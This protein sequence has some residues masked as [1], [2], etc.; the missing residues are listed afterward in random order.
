MTRSKPSD[1]S[2]ARLENARLR[3]EVAG[4]KRRIEELEQ[5]GGQPQPLEIHERTIR[6]IVD[7]VPHIL[8]VKDI[9]GRFLLVNRATATAFGL[10]VEQMTGRAIDEIFDNPDLVARY[11][12]D[13]LEVINTGVAKHIAEEPFIDA[14]GRERWHQAIKIPYRTMNGGKSAILCVSQDITEQK[15]AIESLRQSEQRL[16]HHISHTPL[17]AIVWDMG[18][19]VKE[20]NS[21]AENIF[22]Y[23]AEQAIGRNVMKLIV[24][25]KDRE[26]LND[27]LKHVLEHEEGVYN[28]S[29]NV[30]ES[31]R[32][33]SVEWYNTPLRDAEG[34]AIGVAALALDVTEHERVARSLAKSENKYRSLFET[35]LDGILFTDTEGVIQEANPA[36]LDML[37][38]EIAELRRRS[39]DDISHPD[40]L[41]KNRKIRDRILVGPHGAYEKEYLHK[42]GSWVP[43]SL[44]A[45]PVGEGDGRPERFMG[46]VRD[47][48]ES[49]AAESALEESQQLLRLLSD[50]LPVGIS[51]I[52]QTGRFRFVNKELASWYGWSP[53]DFIGMPVSDLIEEEFQDLWQPDFRRALA[54]EAVKFDL[55]RGWP[56]LGRRMVEITYVPD[57]AADGSVSGLFGLAQDVTEPRTA[58]EALRNSEARRR[59]CGR[60]QQG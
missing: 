15:K 59:R 31:G 22:G 11:R 32:T 3:Q 35:S 9:D 14:Q 49:K 25:E 45:W 26:N 57:I 30:T 1:D 55:E 2:S 38:Y 40:L 60:A 36:L 53:E 50:N 10:T 29:E 12:S 52:D 39:G 19:S 41:E 5:G 34:K 47:I 27:F 44:H 20:W 43:V 46:I 24:P 18:Y 33:V 8:F 58:E 51:Y 48:S 54:G 4:L 21:A 56:I 13:D 37:G 28:T 6:Q 16:S 7:L 23:S 42:D 17:A